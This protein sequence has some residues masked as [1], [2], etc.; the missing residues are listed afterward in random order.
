MSEKN[1]Y[2]NEDP[3]WRTHMQTLMKRKKN[4]QIAQIIDDILC[5]YYSEQGKPVPKWKRKDPDWW[6]DYL[7]QLGIDSRNP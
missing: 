2:E 6:I 4:L 5:E 1:L 7:K 3:T